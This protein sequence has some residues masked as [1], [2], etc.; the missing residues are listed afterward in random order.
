MAESRTSGPGRL[1]VAVYALFAVAAVSRAVVGDGLP[2]ASLLILPGGLLERQ[3]WL[4][5]LLDR[6]DLGGR[7]PGQIGHL[8]RGRIAAER[9][10][11]LA[12][13]SRDAVEPLDDVDRQADRARL[14]RERA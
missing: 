6:L 1:L 9:Q 5:T 8:R 12:L 14:V 13:G 7:H 3:R 4:C 11:Q 10:R 2:E